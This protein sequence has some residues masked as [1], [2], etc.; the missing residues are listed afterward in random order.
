MTA[1]DENR[2]I[3]IESRMAYEGKILN[4]R[5]DQVRMANGRIATREV[6]EH[7]PVVCIAPV[8]ADGNVLMVRQYR[9]PAEATLMECPAGGMYPGESPEEAALRELQEE[10]GFTAGKL[11]KLATFWATPGFCDEKMHAFLASELAPG[12]PEH[13]PDHDEEIES[14][15]WIPLSQAPDLIREG[16]ISDAKSIAS[17]MLAY[18]LLKVGD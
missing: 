18:H 2:E 1:N 8:D 12:D 10:T 16:Q 4:V 17:L 3:T 15:S 14:L 9:K 11:E 13:Q 5:V 7:A 6:V